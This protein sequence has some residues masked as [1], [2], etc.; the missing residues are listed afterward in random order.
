MKT[1]L[2]VVGIGLVS[3]VASV[4]VMSVNTSTHKNVDSPKLES[5]QDSQTLPVNQKNVQNLTLDDSNV[6][7]LNGPILDN[8]AS[9][10]NDIK[11]LYSKTDTIYVLINSPGGSVL[12]GALIVS[13][14][15][16]S[17][18]PVYTVCTQLCASMAAIIHQYGH[19]RLMVDRSTLMFHNAA[20]GLQGQMPEMKNRLAYF[21]RMTMKM[22]AYIAQK[23]GIT[24]DKF[25]LDMSH[26]FWI[27]AEDAVEQH[28]A[29]GVVN[30]INTHTVPVV[31]APTPQETPASGKSVFVY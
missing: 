14:I 22:D 28:Y 8:A 11:D 12:D 20:G 2:V 9:V 3:L 10:A 21:D 17:P 1:G 30:I 19:K 24:L 15:E 27:D 5:K 13:A 16:A 25:L 29:D 7:L 6:I 4:G 23:A 31:P 18:V 26:E